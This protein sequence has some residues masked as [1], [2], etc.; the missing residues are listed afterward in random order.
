LKKNYRSTQSTITV[1]KKAVV[2]LYDL[3]AEVT[4]EADEDALNDF[5]WVNE[6]NQAQPRR[7]RTRPRPP[8]AIPDLPKRV[9]M[10]QMMQTSDGF[11]LTSTDAFTEERLPREIKIEV[12]YEVANGNAF[13][14]YS[15]HD[16]KIGKNGIQCIASKSEVELINAKDNV[17]EIRAITVPFTLQVKGFDK[18]RDLKVKVR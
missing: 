16:F 6:P 15:P 1:I 7:R 18:N 5:F 8:A 4:E 17:L 3:L 12:A 14:K 11:S 9:P 10:L 13:K 2:Q